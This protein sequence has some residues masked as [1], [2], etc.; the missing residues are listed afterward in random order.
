[1]SIK[2]DNAY[3]FFE[4]FSIEEMPDSIKKQMEM[5]LPGVSVQKESRYLT[6]K[7]NTTCNV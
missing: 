7:D 2:F 4:K 1:M 5:R 3:R 6:I